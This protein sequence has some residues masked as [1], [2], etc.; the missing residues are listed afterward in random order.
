VRQSDYLGVSLQ[1]ELLPRVS[2][3]SVQPALVQQLDADSRVVDRPD[4][5]T[6][7]AHSIQAAGRRRLFVT[8]LNIKPNKL[9]SSRRTTAP[10]QRIAA[11]DARRAL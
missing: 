4:Q 3:M 5:F 10:S 11:A 1:Q 7:T 6:V 2:L 8:A 9:I